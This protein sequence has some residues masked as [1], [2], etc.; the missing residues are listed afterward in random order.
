MITSDLPIG[1]VV[2]L[3]SPLLLNF[4][5]PFHHKTI[6]LILKDLLIQ[7]SD[8]M[9]VF[10]K[11]ILSAPAQLTISY[12]NKAVKSFLFIVDIMQ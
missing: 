11:D 12:S 7:S 3:I 5:D 1:T 8:L 2:A 4:N 9:D 6:I 10:F